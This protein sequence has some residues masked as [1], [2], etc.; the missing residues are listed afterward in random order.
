MQENI[1]IYLLQAFGGNFHPYYKRIIPAHLKQKQLG[2]GE[3]GSPAQRH[4]LSATEPRHRA[5]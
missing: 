2:F 4:T 1:Q 5:K 3:A